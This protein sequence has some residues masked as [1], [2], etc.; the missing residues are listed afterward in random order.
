MRTF[1]EHEQRLSAQGGKQ[2]GTPLRGLCLMQ[3]RP[4]ASIPFLCEDTELSFPAFSEAMNRLEKM[5]L[6]REITDQN[7]GMS[8]PVWTTC[9]C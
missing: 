1:E 7:E 3:K 2:A 4:L 8:L 9:K 6:V 5:Q